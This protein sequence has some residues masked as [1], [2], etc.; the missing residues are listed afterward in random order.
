MS[1]YNQWFFGIDAGGTQTCL[2][3]RSIGIGSDF[4]L[5][6]GPANAFRHGKNQAALTISHLINDG[7]NHL[8]HGKLCGIHAG[9]AG[10]GSEHVLKEILEKIYS[11]IKFNFQYKITVSND[12]LIALE[13]ALSGENGLLFIAGTGSGVLAKTGPKLSDMIH[14]GGW[15][16]SIGDEGSGYSI[17]RRTMTAI[18]HAIDGGPATALTDMARSELRIS[19]R[20]SL[21]HTISESNWKFQDLASQTLD[22]AKNGD[23]VATSIIQHETKLL[24]SQ[25]EWIFKK[26]PKLNPI[27]TAIGGL[28]N[29]DYY[30][31]CLCEA[32]KQAWPSLT[33]K[34]P[35]NTPA[36]GAVK[37]AINRFNNSDD[38]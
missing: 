23:E 19:D 21:L 18:A 27:F 29:D 5:S 26:Y 14:I 7:L 2:Y 24:V 15:G 17:G 1:D 25:S 31:E 9:I 36:E 35:L 12:G 16:Y 13:G 30:L 38:Y 33:Y 37:I 3:A 22:A 10:V 32:V 34:T 4:H 11:H 6:G 8:P 20:R 28:T